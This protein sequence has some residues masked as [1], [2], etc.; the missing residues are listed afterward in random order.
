[1]IMDFELQI[2]PLK[3]NKVY[4]SD[5]ESRRSL[6]LLFFLYFSLGMGMSCINKKTDNFILFPANDKNY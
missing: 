6:Y 3:S 1:M 2:M 4:I 5:T